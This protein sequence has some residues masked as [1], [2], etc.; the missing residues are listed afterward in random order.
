M[1]VYDESA[2]EQ[3]ALIDL[4]KIVGFTLG[5][6]AAVLDVRGHVADDWRDTARV[7]IA[8]LEARIVELRLAR[9]LLRHTIDCPHPRLDE[10]PVF[11]AGVADHAAKLGTTP[12]E[13]PRPTPLT[14]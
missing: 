11:R 12:P 8:E 13:R 14:R 9:T 10:C 3:V 2:V 7:K 1:R 4:L 6:I 5:E